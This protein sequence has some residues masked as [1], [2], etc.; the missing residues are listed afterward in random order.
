MDIKSEFILRIG[1]P[2]TDVGYGSFIFEMGHG[3]FGRGCQPY[4]DDSL[5][6]MI[7][8]DHWIITQSSDIDD[9]I[10]KMRAYVGGM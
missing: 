3:L 5:L 8:R 10:T 6:I 4:E 1:V 2:V 7:A 9:G